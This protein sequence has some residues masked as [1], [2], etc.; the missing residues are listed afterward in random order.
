MRVS[1]ST[2]GYSF[3]KALRQSY[4]LLLNL[5]NSETADYIKQVK[6]AFNTIRTNYTNTY[7]LLDLIKRFRFYSSFKCLLKF[8]FCVSSLVKRYPARMLCMLSD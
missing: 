7:V 8:K 5:N 2:S 6:T 3:T 4:P 1:S